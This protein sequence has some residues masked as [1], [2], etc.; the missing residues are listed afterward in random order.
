MPACA[1]QVHF[2]YH[3][4]KVSQAHTHTMWHVL[5]TAQHQ[6]PRSTSSR[7]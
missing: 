4:N 6:Q 7:M 1:A 5:P 3:Q 2:G